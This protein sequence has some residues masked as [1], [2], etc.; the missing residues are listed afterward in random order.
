MRRRFAV[1]LILLAVSRAAFA[2]DIVTAFGQKNILGEPPLETQRE[3]KI[4]IDAPDDVIVK[5][6]IAIIFKDS[7]ESVSDV[8]FSQAKGNGELTFVSDPTSLSVIPDG[9]KIITRIELGFPQDVSK[10]FGPL[11]AGTILVQSDVEPPPAVPE[12]GTMLLFSTGLIGLVP[13]I[14][15]KLRM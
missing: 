1:L 13:V 4:T 3:A 12:T 8:I 10:S 6:K 11:P 5:P 9:Y 7:L 14:R 2:D 15:R